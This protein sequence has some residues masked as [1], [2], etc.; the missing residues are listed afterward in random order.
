MSKSVPFQN[1]AEYQIYFDLGQTAALDTAAKPAKM[2]KLV[3]LLSPLEMD[4]LLKL[5]GSYLQTQHPAVAGSLFTKM[6]GRM[7]TGIW[8]LLTVHNVCV[9]LSLSETK[10]IWSETSGTAS[11]ILP[12]D[13]CTPLPE[14]AGE[15]SLIRDQWLLNMI[16]CNLRPLLETVSF[17]SG[18]SRAILW[19]NVFIYLHHGYSSWIKEA[20]TPQSLERIASDFAAL[21]RQGSPFH[22]PSTSFKNPIYPDEQLRIRRTCCLKH[23]LPNGTHCYSCPNLCNSKRREIYLQKK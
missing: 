1:A 16:D 11:L 8:K 22:I 21:T 18:A 17:R 23:A 2:W 12:D 20:E 4:A 3:S 19:E 10:L 6:M 9:H 15:R 14:L 7:L 5:Y 13:V